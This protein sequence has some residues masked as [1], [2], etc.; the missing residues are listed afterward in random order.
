[1][2]SH[3]ER[4]RIV[5]GK[6]LALRILK[7][8]KSIVVAALIVVYT[9]TGFVLL[10]LLIGRFGPQMLAERLNSPVSLGQVRINPY[11]LKVELRDFRI[12]EPSG[13]PMIG[14]ERL[15][16]NLQ[17]SSLLRWA[18]TFK[19]LTL[20]APALHLRIDPDGRLNLARMAGPPSDEAA[21]EVPADEQGKRPPRLLLYNT[22][23]NEG[24]IELT[25][26][27]QAGPAKVSFH[28]LTI[29]LADIST[30]QGREGDYTLTATGG[31]GTALQWRGDVTLN[32]L[33]SSGTLACRHIPL[34]TPWRFFRSMLDIAPPEGEMHLE[35][36]YVFDLG[37]AENVAHF[38]DL[39]VRLTDLGLRLEGAPLPFLQLPL[40]TL[41]VG[42]V[43]L[44]EHAVDA[45]RL[46]IPGGSLNL[47]R[48][49]AGVLNLQRIVRPTDPAGRQSPPTSAEA[50]PAAWEITIAGIELSDLG[51][52]IRD[53]TTA[54]HRMLSVDGINLGFRAEAAAGATPMTLSVQDLGLDLHR[55]AMGFEGTQRPALEVERLAMSGG[56]LDL[57]GRKVSIERLGLTDGRVDAVLARDGAFNLARLFQDA[58]NEAASPPAPTREEAQ[59]PWRMRV[60]TLAVE[61]FKARF[62]DEALQPGQPIVDLEAIALG[63]SAFDGRSPFPFEA[64]LKVQQGGDL[65]VEGTFDPANITL[66]AK[67]AIDNLALAM[68]QP[69]LDR[70]ADLTLQKGRLSTDGAFSRNDKGEMTYQ[71]SVA[72][73]DL[74]VIENRTRDT[75][76]GWQQLRTP[77]LRL[78]IA[79]NDLSMNAL[80]LTGL[81]GKLII[82]ED[83]TVNVAQAFRPEPEGS[84]S[85]APASPD[86]AAP[87][88]SAAGNGDPAF[89]VRIGRVVLDKGRLQFADLSLK[90]PFG[91]LIHDLGGVITDVASRADAPTQLDLKGTVDRYGTCTITGG[92]SFFD[93]KAHTDVKVTFSNLEMANLTPYSGRFAGRRIDDGRL[94]LDLTYQIEKSR[95]TSHNAIVID[96]LVLGERMESPDAVNLP[97]DLAVALLRDANGIIQIGLP[98]TG[99]LEDPEFRYGQVVRRALFN[100]L[101]RIV[102]SPF[103]ALGGLLGGS[104]ETLDRV[105]F[106][107]GSDTIPPRELEKL[108]K[109]LTALAQRP[110]LQLVIT[111]RYDV[112]FDGRVL[113]ALQVRHALATAMGLKP[114]AYEDPGPVDF[115]NRRVQRRI[116]AM[117]IERHGKAFHDQVLTGTTAAAGEAAAAVAA[118]AAT[119][120]DNGPEDADPAQQAR[121]LFDALVARETLDRDLLR[122]LGDRRA[123][124]VHDLL[125][126]SDRLPSERIATQPTV[127]LEQ[128]EADKPPGVTLGLES[129]EK[130]S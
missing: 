18:L 24:R 62:S 122:A 67:L 44:V 96:A 83:G 5:Q 38:S 102:T 92:I 111:G 89:P 9:L 65:R 107:P 23:I 119:S 104:E 93:P 110:R 73:G 45:L 54:P 60:E 25:D 118:D 123:A 49:E 15:L 95:L 17:I 20:D 48:D 42:G 100:L 29:H 97:L 66:D 28:P 47:I 16:V 53:A 82:A 33:R 27:R 126:G 32:P 72:I 88:K 52:H 115:S 76:V 85:D 11:N 12:D 50:A 59:D 34:E 129:L 105:L 120:D 4:S 116:A 30:L 61:N 64:A 19:E 71:G 75:L 103:R 94:S 8:K 69:Y 87:E 68:V 14:F 117:A 99:S 41:A 31:D 78:R 113:K 106:E 57:D 51:L 130:K 36:R 1:M 3:P 10:P 112:E 86:G 108:D 56:T 101:S 55:I 39:Q 128:T 2:A 74:A 70:V 58:P 6:A 80:H 124:A 22:T 90:P 127:P 91:T 43:D 81:E 13:A 109:L 77:R 26:L 35:T 63:L 84:A 125:T 114:S 40:T 37:Q 21:P 46:T 121:L 79:P 7:S 98:I